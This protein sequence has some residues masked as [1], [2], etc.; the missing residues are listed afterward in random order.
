[1]PEKN[2]SQPR[3]SCSF[4]AFLIL[5]LVVGGV[6]LLS[7]GYYILTTQTRQLYGSP[8][9][10]LGTI[11]RL[12]LSISLYLSQK[13]LFRQNYPSNLPESFS[14]DLGETP[15][16]IANRLMQAG[17]IEDADAFLNYLRYS[18]LDRTLQAGNYA[19]EPG[20]NSLQLAQTLQDA[21]PQEVT[22][23][24]LAGWRIEEIAA[25]L[26]TTGLNIT[27]EE[28]IAETKIHPSGYWFLEEVPK[29]KSLEG[30]LAPGSYRV[31]RESSAKD[32][33]TLLLDT[34]NVQISDQLKAGFENQG[35]SIFAAVKLASIVEREA[36]VDEEMPIIASVF[37]NRL[38][39]GMSLDAD[40]TVQYAMGFN[41]KQNTW[42]T[43]PLSLA[44]LKIKSPY[45]T[46]R[47]PGLPPTP[48]SNPSLN[49]LNAVA[50]PAQSPYYYFRALCDGSGKHIFAETFD[51]QLKNACP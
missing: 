25:T 10:Q 21:T 20:L 47:N 24:V 27:P 6:C 23:P 32:L 31:S 28:F 41:K 30:F 3:K 14:I 26:P 15:Q 9:P 49:A 17:L 51:E 48:I 16:S 11:D 38:A 4:Y 39:A 1:M 22:L 45:N 34:F 42:W 36:M 18:G 2:S 46:Y 40:S 50:F 13:D 43:N 35:L 37:L 29:G 33:I 12:R 19:F 8:S 5:V 7:G 44:N